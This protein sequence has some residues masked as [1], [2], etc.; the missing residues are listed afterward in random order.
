MDTVFNTGSLFAPD[1]L[2]LRDI[3][4]MVQEAYTG[5]VGS[6]YMHIIR[7]EEKRWIQ[8]RLETYRGR[9]E[10]NDEQRR[11]ILHLLTA[12]EGI[13]KFMHARYVG[14]KR[15]SLEG[16]E[17][18]IPMLDELI[19]RAGRDGAKEVVIGMAHRGR[20]NVLANIIGKPP[21]QIFG[22]FAGGTTGPGR[23]HPVLG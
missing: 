17:S 8:Q 5:N 6:E 11:W 20:L 23:R 18:L 10:L 21:A 9:P 16:G 2:P 13:E 15:F 22:E 1:Q 12:S 4:E 3:L 7:T 19:Q 14:Q